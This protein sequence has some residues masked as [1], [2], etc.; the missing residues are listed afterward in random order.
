VA[1]WEGTVREGGR[2]KKTSTERNW[3][4]QAEAEQQ[5]GISH[6]QVSRWKARLRDPDKYRQMLVGVVARPR[7]HPSKDFLV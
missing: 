7:G 4:S 3:I 1:W 5:T 6:V 2:P